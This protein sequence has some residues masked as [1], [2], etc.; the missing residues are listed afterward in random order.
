MPA[1]GDTYTIRARFVVDDQS[2][3]GIGAASRGVT[4]L[5][6]RVT[7][8]GSRMS[9]AFG[10]AIGLL[11]GGLAFGAATRGIIRMN[12]QVDT[13]NA[14]LATLFSAVT[15]APIEQAMGVARKS[16][17]GLRQ[18]AAAGVGELQ[19]YVAGFQSVIAPVLGAGK[20]T[21][22][23]RELTR[24]ALGAGFALQG[25]R[26]L[27]NASMDIQQALTAGAGQRT[28]P[29][30]NAALR[31]IGKTN[32]QFN[33]LSVGDRIDTLNEAFGAFAPGVE[34]MG[35][36]WEAQMGTMRDNINNILLTVTRPIFDRW[37]D[38]LI[39][40][41]SWLKDNKDIIEEMATVGGEKL[42]KMW[43]NL[44]ANA[45]T[46]ASIVGGAS[47]AKGV[48]SVAGAAG[49]GVTGVGAA[50]LAVVSVAIVGAALA[51]SG[52]LEQWPSLMVGIAESGDRLWESLLPLGEAFGRLSAEGSLLNVV[53]A[54]IV[55]VFVAMV[56]K[57]TQTVQVL[58]FAV[59]AFGTFIRIVG[60]GMQS[61]VQ[62]AFAF[63]SGDLAGV[64]AASQTGNTAITNLM[65]GFIDRQ[66]ERKSAR[67]GE[68]PG[69]EDGLGDLPT[70]SSITNINGPINV[71]MK[72]EQNADPARV[73]TS[74]KE[75]L[76][77]AVRFKDGAAPERR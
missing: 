49:V 30:V 24:N 74:W 75:V 51:V 76:E 66:L 72:V 17:V 68:A 45:R 19:D 43:D 42:L 10:S 67:K 28:T 62:Q 44:I 12:D 52:A 2:G 34:L 22:V 70:S 53:G 59:D 65:Q 63:A 61:L 23:A 35:Q 16:I 5:E 1:G 64:S 27:Q 71:K 11:A 3:R 13:A 25:Q 20:G 26:G 46:Y 38:S 41:N 21:E 47:L 33:Q 69:G 54:A 56:D 77:R 9:S 73:L 60:V 48:G 32:E 31:A 39:A 57:V 36:T 4:Q 55:V 15:G 37:K 29:I 58:T 14:G 40:A 18:D 8:A 7:A 6:N 50:G